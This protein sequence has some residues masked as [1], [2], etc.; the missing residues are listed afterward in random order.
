LQTEMMRFGILGSSSFPV[1]W[2]YEPASS[3]LHT[4]L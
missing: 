4:I 2:R 3:F 1:L